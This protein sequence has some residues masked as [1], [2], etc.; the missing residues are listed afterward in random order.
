MGRIRA[1][2]RRHKVGGPIGTFLLL[3][4]VIGQ[5]LNWV[6]LIDQV[7]AMMEPNHWFTQ[8]IFWPHLDLVVTAC[9]LLL[10]LYLILNEKPL[11]KLT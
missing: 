5:I 10:L 3:G 2:Y 4:S 6:G 1:F 9:G 7:R 8:I 11:G